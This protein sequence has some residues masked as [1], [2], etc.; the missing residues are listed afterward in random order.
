MKSIL[1][2]ERLWDKECHEDHHVTLPLKD[3]LGPK[4][5]QLDLEPAMLHSSPWTV[6]NPPRPQM[7][8]R[9]D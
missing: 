5:Y 1:L 6:A 3:R 9:E 8:K 4:Q 2:I 7:M